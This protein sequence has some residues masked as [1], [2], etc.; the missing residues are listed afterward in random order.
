MAQNSN[1]ENVMPFSYHGHIYL[2]T[3]VNDSVHLN[4]LFD[5][6]AANLFGIDSVALLQSVWQPLKIG[7]AVAGGASGSTNVKIIV[8]G[9]KVRIGNMVQHYDIVPIFKL[10]D[11][12][13]RYVDAIWGIKDVSKYP[14][15]INFEQQYV[16]QYV[17]GMPDTEHFLKIPVEYENNRIKLEAEVQ[18]GGKTIRGWFLMDTGSGGS[19]SFTSK[20]VGEYGIDKIEGRRYH[21]DISQF[22]LGDK[23]METAV[24]MMSDHLIIGTDTI[25]NMEIEYLPE[26]TGALG[27]RPYLGIIGNAVWKKFN[28]IIDVANR[29][30]YLK[31]F[32]ADEPDGKSFGYGWRNRTDICRGWIVSH[33]IREGQAVSAGLAI[34]D[35]IIAVNG[36]DV[37]DYTWDEEDALEKA[38]QHQLDIITATGSRKHIVL[39]SK[40]YW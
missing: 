12:V 7:K 13:D 28:I 16:K 15:E 36:R 20:A 6:G 32:K 1:E 35:T 39:E 24:L 8:D 40:E 22:G 31:R 10:R 18:L 2:N 5:T 29:T 27:D 21:D 19:I 34:G 38:P 14:L 26:G 33:M 9:T 3:I 25:R 30:L 11:V 37:N 17:T 23:P 4:T